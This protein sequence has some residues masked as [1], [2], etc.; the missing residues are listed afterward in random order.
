MQR[1]TWSIMTVAAFDT[2]FLDIL[3]IVRH[4]MQNCQQIIFAC[5]CPEYLKLGLGIDEVF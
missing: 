5:I 3:D 1:T 2:F 4:V